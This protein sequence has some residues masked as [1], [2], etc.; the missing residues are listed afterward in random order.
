MTAVGW[1]LLDS[2]SPGIFTDGT[3]ISLDMQLE[4]RKKMDKRTMAKPKRFPEVWLA[5]GLSLALLYMI[6]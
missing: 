3:P 4:Y 2:L 5:C 6:G 1:W